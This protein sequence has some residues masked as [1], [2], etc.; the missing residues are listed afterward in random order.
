MGSSAASSLADSAE[1][2]NLANDLRGG[3]TKT[4]GVTQAIQP[5]HYEQGSNIAG[6]IASSL[7]N[8]AGSAFGSSAAGKGLSTSLKSAFGR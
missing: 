4:L 3:T 5:V 1:G 6:T 7:G 8:I 2:I